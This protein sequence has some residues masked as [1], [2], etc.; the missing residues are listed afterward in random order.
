MGSEGAMN[1]RALLTG[2]AVAAAVAVGC[3]GQSPS[4]PSSGT[5]LVQ[6]LVLGDGASVTASSGVPIAAGKSQKVTVKV[7]GTSITAEVSANGTFEIKDIPSGTFT[8]VFLVDGVEIGRVVVTAEEGSEVKIVVQVKNS[9]LV[10]I[11]IKVESPG[12]GPGPSP[13]PA[14]GACLINGGKVGQGIE[15]EGNVASG[16]EKAF[17]MSAAG[18]TGLVD[19]SAAAASFRCIGNAKVPTDAECRASVKAGA[20]VH[21]R[22]TLMACSTAKAEVTAS[23]VKVQKD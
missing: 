9:V 10:L 4:S 23:E 12:S 19:V 11:E 5:V 13:S 21:V 6:G 15:L 3:G 16:D 20:K 7:D 1:R 2:V 18:A 14:A 8:L 22:G 17:Q